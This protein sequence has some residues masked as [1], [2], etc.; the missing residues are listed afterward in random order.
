MKSVENG[1]RIII[2]MAVLALLAALVL[3]SLAM[4]DG[5]TALSASFSC[6]KIDADGMPVTRPDDSG[7]VSS[8]LNGFG[9]IRLNASLRYV[10][11]TKTDEMPTDVQLAEIKYRNKEGRTVEKLL[12]ARDFYTGKTYISREDGEWRLV[13]FPKRIDGALT[14]AM[15]SAALL[16]DDVPRNWRGKAIYCTEEFQDYNKDEMTFRYR[17]FWLDESIYENF[18]GYK[19]RDFNNTEPTEITSHEDAIRRAAEELGIEDPIAVTFYDETCGY[20]LVEIYENTTYTPTD[21]SGYAD[22]LT[23]LVHRGLLWT[24]IMNEKGITLE[25]YNAITRYGPFMDLAGL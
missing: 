22:Y 4:P 25:V 23:D 13:K 18:I 19:N 21:K 9:Q 11:G 3:G 10:K 2:G 5:A 8:N 12:V 14:E 7:V 20:R 1:K 15:T 16:I 17:L 6:V 24:V